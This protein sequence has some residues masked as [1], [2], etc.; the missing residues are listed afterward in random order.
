ML[1]AVGL[2]LLQTHAFRRTGGS[3]LVAGICMHAGM[4]ITHTAIG[5]L[6]LAP[7]LYAAGA[8]MTLAGLLPVARDPRWW[9]RHPKTGASRR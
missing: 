4:N 2:S 6:G 3:V 5:V 8:L 9:F 1:G 7:Y